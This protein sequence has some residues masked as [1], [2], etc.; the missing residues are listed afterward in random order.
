MTNALYTRSFYEPPESESIPVKDVNL[1]DDEE[2]EEHGEEEAAVEEEEIEE[3]VC[4]TICFSIYLFSII[5][6]LNKFQLGKPCFY[7]EQI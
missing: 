1:D 2:E 7:F 5:V 3:E 6:Y 4:S